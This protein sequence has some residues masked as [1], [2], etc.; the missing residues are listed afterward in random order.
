MTTKTVAPLDEDTVESIMADPLTF[1]VLEELDWT[2]VPYGTLIRR[3]PGSGPMIGRLLEAGIIH[4]TREGLRIAEAY[5]GCILG[6]GCIAPECLFIE[7]MD[8]HRRFG[9]FVSEAAYMLTCSLFGTDIEDPLYTDA[10]DLL[11]RSG[12]IDPDGKLTEEG[13]KVAYGIFASV[14]RI[15]DTVAVDPDELYGRWMP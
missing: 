3:V 4:E 11:V 5:Q 7:P 13:R 14:P 2:T 9:L 1:P 15:F 12:L 6:S 10:E 8:K